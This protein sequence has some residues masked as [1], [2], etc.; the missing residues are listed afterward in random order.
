MLELFTE[1]IANTRV[2]TYYNEKKHEILI[3]E[4]ADEVEV[5]AGNSFSSDH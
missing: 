5:L 3:K 2:S 4:D 1:D